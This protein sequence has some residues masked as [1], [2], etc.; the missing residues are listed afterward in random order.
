MVRPPDR[1]SR[2]QTVS[3]SY[4]LQCAIGLL[5]FFGINTAIRNQAWSSTLA[6]MQDAHA[7]A[8]NSNRAA[9]NLA[10]EYFLLGELDRALLLSEQAFHLWHPT[11]NYAE[12]ISL[13]AQGVVYNRRGDD[14]ESNPVIS[15]KPGISSH[16]WTEAK[17]NLIVSLMQTAP[18]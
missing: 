13:N 17:K 8:P 5:L 4:S 7:K 16:L 6:L 18:V 12:A 14:S 11:K 9:T 1:S 2:H 10:K 3:Q 15:A